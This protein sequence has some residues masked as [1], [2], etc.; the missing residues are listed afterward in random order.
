MATTT[1][2]RTRKQVQ[3]T[4]QFIKTGLVNLLWITQGNKTDGYFGESFRSAVKRWTETYGKPAKI[5]RYRG[6]ARDSEAAMQVVYHP[7][8]G[9]WRNDHAGIDQP[10]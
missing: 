10:R 4:M 6:V 8:D 5:I 2:K 9:N 7:G 1:T 3:R